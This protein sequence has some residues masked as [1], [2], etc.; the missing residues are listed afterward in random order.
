MGD[1]EHIERI[2]LNET[3]DARNEGR[4]AG[5]KEA[6]DNCRCPGCA[7]D[8]AKRVAELEGSGNG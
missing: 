3:A 7:E 8:I 5:L 1:Y 6:R 2:R 4:I